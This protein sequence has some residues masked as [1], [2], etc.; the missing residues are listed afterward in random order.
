MG[1]GT[2][3]EEIASNRS[4]VAVVVVVAGRAVV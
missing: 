1:K 4:Q 3:M 2:G